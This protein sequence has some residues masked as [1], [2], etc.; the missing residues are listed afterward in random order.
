MASHEVVGM[1]VFAGG[2][3]HQ[4]NIT[5]RKITTKQHKYG[6]TWPGSSGDSHV[7]VT[8]RTLMVSTDALYS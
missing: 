1:H 4:P 5:W 3:G 8:Q 6:Q 7:L 2:S